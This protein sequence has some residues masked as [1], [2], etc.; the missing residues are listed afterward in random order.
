MTGARAAALGALAVAVIVV[1]VVLLTGGGGHTYKV[2]FQSAGQLVKDD[3]VQIGGRRIGSVRKIELTDNNQ[4]EIE[5]NVESPYAPLHVGTTAAIRAT[6][7]SGVANRYIALT[8][9]PDKGTPKLDDGAV[10]QQ[11][12]TTP[13]VDLDQLFNTLDP[14]T[15]RSLQLVIKGS[16][17]W[18]QGRGKTN[19]QAAKYFNPAISTSANLVREVNRDQQAFED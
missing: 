9:A 17:Q 6:S 16:A 11:D 18:Y 7:L 5:I 12:K 2:R 14:K 1:G 3:D 19:N 10:L 8:P 13:I 4:A 15:R